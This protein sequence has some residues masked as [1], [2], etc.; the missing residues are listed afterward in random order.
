M[1]T[2]KSKTQA[3]A[4]ATRTPEVKPRLNGMPKPTNSTTLKSESRKTTPATPATTSKARKSPAAHASQ[5]AEL[6]EEY[7]TRLRDWLDHTD[8][9]FAVH[10]VPLSRKRKRNNVN[11]LQVQDDLFQ[12]RLT[13]QYEVKP[14]DKWESLRR[15]KK[16]T[17]KEDQSKKRA[18]WKDVTDN[19]E[20]LDPKALRQASVSWSSTTK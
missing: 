16:F 11:Q 14:R 19:G 12:E 6:S 8:N 3:K 9:P 1:R 13:V 2:K 17:G 4:P 10:T 15:Y 5:P 20:Q 18:P 7:R